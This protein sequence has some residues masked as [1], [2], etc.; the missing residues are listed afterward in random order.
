MVTTVSTIEN[1]TFFTLFYIWLMNIFTFALYAYDKHQAYYA[2]YRVP[3][4]VLIIFS[5]IGGAFG[6]WMAMWLFHHK[7]RKPKFYITV[8][9]F[10]M[11]ICL[12]CILFL[13]FPIVQ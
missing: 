3:E 7:I 8:P 2:K 6:A 13:K 11:V 5:V 12:V 4:L 1:L 9:I 10:V